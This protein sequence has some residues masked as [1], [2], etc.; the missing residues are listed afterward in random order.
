M[1]VC[2]PLTVR[3]AAQ[4]SERN[5]LKNCVSEA[6][7]LGVTHF[8]ILTVIQ[9]SSCLKICKTLRVRACWEAL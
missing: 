7:P 9:N 4:E 6:G 2:W 5:E 3:Q 1:A 8:V